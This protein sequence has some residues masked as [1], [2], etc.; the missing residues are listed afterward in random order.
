MV[1]SGLLPK[2]L[3]TGARYGAI[4]TIDARGQALPARVP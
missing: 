3:L 2:E 1:L 4:T